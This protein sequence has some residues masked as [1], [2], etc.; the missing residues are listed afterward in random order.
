[1]KIRRWSVGVLAASLLVPTLT[2]CKSDTSASSEPS[3]AGSAATS[4]PADPKAKLL[5]ST[6]AI[7]A[8]NFRFTLVGADFSGGG[9]VHA[10]S[11]SAQMKMQFGDASSDVSM[12]LDLVHVQPDSYVK[13]KV[14]GLPG[15]E[16]L[17]DKYQH[18]D[19][20]RIKD[21][22]GLDFDFSQVDP[23][24]SDVLIK[25]VTDV[26]E[27]GAGAY[28]GKL[29]ISGA[30]D[31]AALDDD[32]ITALGV[33]AKTLPFTAKVDDQG[34]LTEMVISIPAAGETKAHDVKVTYSE[35]GTT[36][37]V[38][39]PPADQV[40]EASDDVYKMFS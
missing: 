20:S 16:K 35:Y 1:M 25:T 30:T 4:A 5:A 17:G 14:A 34:R 7:G 6:E 24:N 19:Q 28:S 40:V 3:T 29:D 31:S 32:L 13:L 18:L 37:A 21:A 23:V 11:K 2:A 27:T 10:A 33:Q 26:Q 39:K 38:Q 15:A 9:T 8:G 22:K 12:S 36:T